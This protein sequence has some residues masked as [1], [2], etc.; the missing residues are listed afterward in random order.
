MP[1]SPVQA[2][3]EFAAPPECF[4]ALVIDPANQHAVAFLRD[5]AN[6]PLSAACLIGPPRS[7]RT[8]LG[9]CWAHA[10]GATFVAADEPLLGAMPDGSVCVDDADQGREDA[11][12]LHLLNA[13]AET[14][15]HTL[16]TAGAPPSAWNV[17][18][19]DLASRLAAM[20]V[21]S[22]QPP[23]AGTLG[24]RLSALLARRA[25]S[26]PPEVLSYL[27]PRLNRTY[28]DIELCATRLAGA[29]GS[30]RDLTVALAGEVLKQMY[31][32]GPVA[33]D[34]DEQD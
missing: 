23:L 28:S 22:I 16:L 3:F 4:D 9:R 17:A 21:I 19:K 25:L 20:P 34:D 18:N 5:T 26:V 12:L 31:G 27:E 14:G 11:A 6:W 1:R 2:S 33:G 15:A 30:G 8:T 29:A 24:A 13:R 7:G 32:A 10:Q